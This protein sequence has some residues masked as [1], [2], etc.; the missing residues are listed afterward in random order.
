MDGGRVSGPRRE[1]VMGDP[2]PSP[3]LVNPA[4]V[5]QSQAVRPGE[6]A[7]RRGVEAT[8]PSR[9]KPGAGF[10]RFQGF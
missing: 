9:L 3:Q 4:V 1:P 7:M 10:G 6:N 8:E 2:E 5:I